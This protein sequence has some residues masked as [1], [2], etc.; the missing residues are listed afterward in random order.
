MERDLLDCLAAQLECGGEL[1][2]ASDV[3]DLGLDAL[4]ELESAHTLGFRNLCGPWTFARDYP[5]PAQS[6]RERTTLRRQQR[7]WRLRFAYEGPGASSSSVGSGKASG[8]SAQF[9]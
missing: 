8:S 6:R 1:H 5:W 7:V 9:P 2:F 4:S 3:F